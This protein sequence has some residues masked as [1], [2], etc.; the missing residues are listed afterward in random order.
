MKTFFLALT[1]LLFAR[2][3]LAET[4]LVL[5]NERYVAPY[6]KFICNDWNQN[7]PVPPDFAARGVA[8]EKL[9]G[10]QSLR[11]FL[12]T[13]N[14]RAPNGAVCRYNVMLAL[15]ASKKFVIGTGSKAYVAMGVGDCSQGKA[16]LDASFNARLGY[17]VDAP[18]GFRFLALQLPARGSAC[19]NQTI[20][21]V[22]QVRR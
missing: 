13:A 18:R 21:A 15:D 1:A 3:A 2:P 5:A 6:V 14:F 12:L 19:G 11:N 4:D 10:D 16:V 7:A 22:F 8:F 17:A 20:Q 9:S